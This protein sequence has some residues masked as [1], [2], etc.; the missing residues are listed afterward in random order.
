MTVT[1]NLEFSQWSQVFGSEQLTGILLDWLTH[2]T[3]ILAI[4]GESSRFRES[5]K[6][7]GPE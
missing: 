2:H 4:N 5:L 7:V 6:K 3:H 1:T